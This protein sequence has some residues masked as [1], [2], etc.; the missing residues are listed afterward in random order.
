MIEAILLSW[1]PLVVVVDHVCLYNRSGLWMTIDSANS[2]LECWRM[3]YTTHNINWARYIAVVKPC[4]C[5]V[6]VRVILG[7]HQPS[8]NVILHKDRGWFVQ[9]HHTYSNLLPHQPC[10]LANKHM[11]N[12]LRLDIYKLYRSPLYF[13]AAQIF[14]RARPFHAQSRPPASERSISAAQPRPL[15]ALRTLSPRGIPALA[16]NRRAC[17]SWE[18]ASGWHYRVFIEAV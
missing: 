12:S 9:Y 8:S 5:F 10:I 17:S 6:T 14:P 16:D 15:N 7:G 3:L 4:H 11:Q 1:N 2:V 13:C 18:R